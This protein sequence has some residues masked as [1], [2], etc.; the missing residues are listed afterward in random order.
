MEQ[1]TDKDREVI[2][3][4]P[5]L[6]VDKIFYTSQYLALAVAL[7]PIL[8]APNLGPRVKPPGW[9]P[10]KTLDDYFSRLSPYL[11]AFSLLAIL[12]LLDSIIRWMELRSGTKKIT[13]LTV[14]KKWVT[15]RWTIIIFKPF[16]V[17]IFRYFFRLRT[18]Q[19]GDTINVELTSLNRII[20][21]TLDSNNEAAQDNA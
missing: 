19:E 13:K 8:I 10:P 12:P 6:R 2:A 20:D 3:E 15:K 18:V 17:S 16:H 14:T 4:T 9:E 1:L 11:V 21:F 5:F 7:I